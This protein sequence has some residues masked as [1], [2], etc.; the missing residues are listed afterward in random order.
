MSGGPVNI[1]TDG[2]VALQ[3]TE[4]PLEVGQAVKPDAS[5]VGITPLGIAGL[6]KSPFLLFLFLVEIRW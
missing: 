3:M 1:P 4:V 6:H 5:H 2:K